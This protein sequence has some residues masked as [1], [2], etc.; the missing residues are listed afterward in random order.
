MKFKLMVQS[1]APLALLTIISNFSFQ[2]QDKAGHTFTSFEFVENNLI[3]LCV[4]LLCALWLILALIYYF[5]FGVFRWAGKNK[6]RGYEIKDVK[7]DKEASLNFFL[8]LIIPLL[9]DNISTIQG[10]ITF[11]FI[12]LIICVLLYR[13]NLFFANPILALLGYHLYEFSF[14][15][16][17]EFGDKK[18][19][20][21]CKGKVSSEQSI[22][23]KIISNNVLYIRRL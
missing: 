1:L 2:T 7:E 15:E 8:T 14:K 19:L 12:L 5:D 6:E 4:M 16:N 3:L 9:L 18:C 22:E 13:T 21:L 10:A 23:Y 11:I 17:K 20:G